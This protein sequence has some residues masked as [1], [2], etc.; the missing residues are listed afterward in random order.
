MLTSFGK[1][2]RNRSFGVKIGQGE[3]L[4]DII[5]NSKGVVEGVPTLELVYN[6]AEKLHLDLPLTKTIY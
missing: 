1:L 6:T 2:S 5:K 4:A 3:K